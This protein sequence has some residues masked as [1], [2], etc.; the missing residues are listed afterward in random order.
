[1]AVFNCIHIQYRVVTLQTRRD[2]PLKGI[3][4]V[5]YHLVT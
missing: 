1:M 3:N 4:L 5:R 2:V